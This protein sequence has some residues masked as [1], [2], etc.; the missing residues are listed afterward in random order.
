MNAIAFWVG[1]IGSVFGILTTV[2]GTVV[3]YRTNIRNKY[4]A[5]RDFNHLKRNY[6][7]LA[8]AFKFQ[9]GEMDDH[10]ERLAR[11]LDTRCDRLDAEVREIKALLLSQIGIRYKDHE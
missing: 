4:A 11:D 5:E 6:E 2:A 3:W 1:A 7:G 9:T 10:F 8:E